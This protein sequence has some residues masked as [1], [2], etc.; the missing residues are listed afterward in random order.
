MLQSR[1]VASPIN[2]DLT[3]SDCNDGDQLLYDA[4]SKYRIIMG[5]LL[6]MAIKSGLYLVVA[7]SIL[8]SYVSKYTENI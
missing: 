2:S 4:N 3:D 7:A 5:S 8:G 6:Y 1:A